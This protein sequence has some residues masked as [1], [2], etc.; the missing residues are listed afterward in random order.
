MDTMSKNEILTALLVLLASVGLIIVLI[1]GFQEA[2]KRRRYMQ[3]W[4]CPKCSYLISGAVMES[5]RAWGVCPRCKDRKF[6]QFVK[7]EE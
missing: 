2:T 6:S 1:V 7:R 3:V 4:K 5:N